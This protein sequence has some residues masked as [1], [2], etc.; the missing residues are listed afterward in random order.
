[1]DDERHF[2]GGAPARLER[3]D[4]AGAAAAAGTIAALLRHR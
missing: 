3:A 1:V 2:H 4:D